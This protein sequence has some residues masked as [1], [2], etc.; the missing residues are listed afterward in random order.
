M[1][2]PED[3]KLTQAKK[4]VAK[5]KEQML[6]I[7]SSKND[8]SLAEAAKDSAAIQKLTLKPRRLLKGHLA[9]V[10]DLQWCSDKSHIVSAAQDG[11]LLV[12]DAM[13]QNKVYALGLR[14]N[15]VLCCG[16]SQNGGLVAAGGL[17][18]VCAVFN[19]RSRE[20]E[21]AIRQYRDLNGHTGYI[22]CCQFLN[23]REI[24][25][26]SGDNTCILWDID[27]SQKK[28]EFR[29]CD[30]DIQ[31]LSIKPAEESTFITG[32]CDKKAKLWDIRS[33][34]CIQ[35]FHGH[36]ND[37]N[38]VQFFPNGTCFGTGSEDQHCK[39]FDIR[40]GQPLADYHNDSIT[41]GV[42]SVAFSRSGRLLFASYDDLNVQVW[43]TLKATK[44]GTL[45]IHEKRVNCLGV[46]SDGT[47]LATGSWDTSVRVWA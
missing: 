39:L 23:D 33:G 37:V 7:F 18:N 19:L 36:T 40:A 38:S 2:K 21:K 43:D 29:D 14:C 27:S 35:N 31:S 42:T 45:S 32:G 3:P 25:T 13:T 41:V 4:D 26:T 17:D 24:I 10:Y 28:T 20:P 9:K 47:S 22:S 46:S 34:K 44:V 11:K 5:L 1:E 30:Q 15:W 6:G 16:Y 12:W 8:V